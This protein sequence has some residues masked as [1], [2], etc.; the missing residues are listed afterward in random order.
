MSVIEQSTEDS[1]YRVQC[2]EDRFYSCAMQCMA[3]CSVDYRDC[4]AVHYIAVDFIAAHSSTVQSRAG[5]G[6]ALFLVYFKLRLRK[7]LCVT[8]YSDI[9]DG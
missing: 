9:K 6:N 4:A 3:Q 7:W 5:K 2:S 8:F 1:F